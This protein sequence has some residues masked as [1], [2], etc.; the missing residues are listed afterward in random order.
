MGYATAGA[1]VLAIILGWA[2]NAIDK[3]LEGIDGIQD[4]LTRV[5]D[6]NTSLTKELQRTKEQLEK[7]IEIDRRLATIELQN[8]P[9]GAR[10]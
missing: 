1:T 9:K 4:R 7:Q 2:F 3:R 8:K 10:K 5:E 6:A